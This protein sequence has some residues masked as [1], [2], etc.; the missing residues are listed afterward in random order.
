[1]NKTKSDLIL[2]NMYINMLGVMK[3]ALDVNSCFMFDDDFV[4]HYK[5]LIGTID[6]LHFELKDVNKL[7]LQESVSLNL[8]MG[9]VLDK[10]RLN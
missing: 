8:A 4:S 5:I 6:L 1:M 9:V 2:L 10:S 3:R 7:Y